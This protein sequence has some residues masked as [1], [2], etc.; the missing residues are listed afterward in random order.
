MHDDA[1]MSEPVP[2][3]ISTLLYGIE[4]RALGTG[5]VESL[6]GHLL[7]LAHA[8]SLG[9][10]KLVRVTLASD[11]RINDALTPCRREKRIMRLLHDRG[12]GWG[13]G[14]DKDAGKTMI[15]TG[16]GA[17]KWAHALELATGVRN[18]E[19]TTLGNLSSI[20]STTKL[21]LS[22]QRVCVACVNA[23]TAKGELP[24]ERL[25]WRMGAVTCCPHH[26]V[27]LVAARCAGA[28]LKPKGGS[29]RLKHGGACGACGAIGFTCLDGL[30]L[31]LAT[32]PEIWRAK[33]CHA[34]LAGLET[35]DATAPDHVKAAFRKL[36]EERGGM[37]QIAS[38]AAA[39][40]SI[41]SRWLGKP[42]ARISLEQLLDI[43]AAEGISLLGLLQGAVIDVDTPRECRVPQRKKRTVSRVDHLMV[44]VSM[45]E[46]LARGGSPSSLVKELK[47]DYATLAKHDVLYGELRKSKLA[48]DAASAALRR[49]KADDEA[50]AMA[51]LLVSRRMTVSLTNAGAISGAK[52]YP[53]ALRSKALRKLAVEL[54]GA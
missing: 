4:P 45:A 15:G 42:R 46:A 17:K 35:L 41:I 9:P 38:R 22:E 6:F 30:T 25:L 36:A 13:W 50:R 29:H 7:S 21:I 28:T 47:V 40:K 12:W 31:E 19:L 27:K 53:S 2:K 10:D 16:D 34:L 32:L 54:R 51:E 26:E 18:L 20:V 8:H 1:F 49:Q 3:I 11:S 39:P 52:W 24:Y 5:E 44:N 23:D 37:Q 43:A 14:W 33:Q 48:M